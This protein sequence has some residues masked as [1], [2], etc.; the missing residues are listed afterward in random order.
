MSPYTAQPDQ[1]TH[2]VLKEAKA[3]IMYKSAQSENSLQIVQ[4]LRLKGVLIRHS[5]PCRNSRAMSHTSL[6]GYSNTYISC[7]RPVKAKC[8]KHMD[9]LYRSE[10]MRGVFFKDP[11]LVA[12]RRDRN[13]CGTLVHSKTNKSLKPTSKNC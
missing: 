7:L 8:R 4:L 5:K 12:F 10:N 11:P 9:V 6:G 13:M 3:Q 1:C 2:C